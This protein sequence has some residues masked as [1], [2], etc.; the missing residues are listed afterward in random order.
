MTEVQFLLAHGSRNPQW[1]KPFEQIA[2]KL[3]SA[4]PERQI[5]LCYLEMWEPSLE[6]AL[7]SAYASGLRH[8]RISPLFWSSGRH[9]QEDLPALLEQVQVTLP[10]CLIK[11]EGPIGESE[12][13]IQA[14][15]QALQ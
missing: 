6:Q 10:D 1:R 13:I 7:H 3:Q 5:V 15:L 9:L 12:I 8:F 2:E 14:A 11:V 4:H